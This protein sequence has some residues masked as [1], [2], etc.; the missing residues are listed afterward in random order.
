MIVR[1][2]QRRAGRLGALWCLAEVFEAEVSDTMSLVNKNIED[3]MLPPDVILGGIIR[4]KEFMIPVEGDMVRSG[5]ILIILATQ[6]Q[7]KALEKI[8]SVQVD[9]F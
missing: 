5:D 7:A 1:R 6:Q 9:L 8:F 2:F 4:E 3:L